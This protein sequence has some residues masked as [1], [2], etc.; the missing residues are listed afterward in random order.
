MGAFTSGLAGGEDLA[1][2]QKA[3]EEAQRTAQRN[4]LGAL[5]L[6]AINTKL[7]QPDAP[8]YAEALKRREDLMKQM[9]ALNTPEQH[10]SF[11][12][13]LHGLIFGKNEPPPQPVQVAVNPAT[14][15]GVETPSGP[16]T[17]LHPFTTS[18]VLDKIHQGLGELEKHL[19][20]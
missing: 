12:D 4:T 9:V 19:K 5:Y 3:K 11:A 14:D 18:P 15:A 6:N 16:S 1:L 10:A 2:Q 17:P 7:P 13:R 20:G 8:E